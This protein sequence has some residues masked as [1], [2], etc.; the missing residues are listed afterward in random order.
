MWRARLRNID[1]FPLYPVVGMSVQ[2]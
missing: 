1:L 2:F